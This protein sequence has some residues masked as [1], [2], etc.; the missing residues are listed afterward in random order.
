MCACLWGWSSPLIYNSLQAAL[1]YVGPVLS[2]L[3]QSSKAA[4][5]SSAGGMATSRAQASTWHHPLATPD[6]PLAALHR[7][8]WWAA[9]GSHRQ[10]KV[11]PTSSRYLVSSALHHLSVMHR[12]VQIDAGCKNAAPKDTPPGCAGDKAHPILPAKTPL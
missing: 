9:G 6:P 1:I 8:G 12:Y 2:S 3:R 7:E 11:H 10:P 4:P 5:G